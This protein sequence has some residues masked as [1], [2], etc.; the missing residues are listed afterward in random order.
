MLNKRLGSNA[1]AFVVPSLIRQPHN[2]AQLSSDLDPQPACLR[3]Q[4]DHLN[5]APYDLPRLGAVLGCQYSRE[6]A[7]P[8]AVEISKVGVQARGGGLGLR[9]LGLHQ[10][11][12]R[13][14]LLQPA[15]ERRRG[16]AGQDGVHRPLDLA[17]HPLQFGPCGVLPRRGIGL[18]PV[19]GGGELGDEVA[20]Q[21]GVHQSLA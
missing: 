5:Q 13:L 20:E 15:P 17:A 14:Q 2:G 8:L 18:Q 12:A 10:R 11:L 1:G 19:P 3:Q 6:V 7:D 16:H 21:I 9:Q 4:T